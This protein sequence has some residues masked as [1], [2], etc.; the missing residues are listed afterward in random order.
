MQKNLQSTQQATELLLINSKQRDHTRNL[1]DY[2]SA[3]ISV[4][5]PRLLC[6]SRLSKG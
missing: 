6:C 4:Y 5:Q 1:I 2:V 3:V